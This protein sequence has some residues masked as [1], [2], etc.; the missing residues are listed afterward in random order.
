MRLALLCDPTGVLIVMMS[1]LRFLCMCERT[2]LAEEVHG[3]HP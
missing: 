2:F 1:V 3:D